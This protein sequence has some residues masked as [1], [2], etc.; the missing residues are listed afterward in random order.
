MDKLTK[1]HLSI[2]KLREYTKWLVYSRTDFENFFKLYSSIDEH[3]KFHTTTDELKF[4]TIID[5]LKFHTIKDELTR[6][7][8]SWLWEFLQKSIS[9]GIWM[10]DEGFTS[11]TSHLKRGKK[12]WKNLNKTTKRELIYHLNPPLVSHLMYHTSSGIQKFA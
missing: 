8:T 10:R 3:A 6:R 9:W 11:D 4:H 7:L 12:S 2:G 1:F 5:R